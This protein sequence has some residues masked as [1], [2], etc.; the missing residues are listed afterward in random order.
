MTL[1]EAAAP[2]AWRTQAGP[3]SLPPHLQQSCH[4][5]EPKH[6][7]HFD[8]STNII[9][10]ASQISRLPVNMKSLP[11]VYSSHVACNGKAATQYRLPRRLQAD[12][13]QSDTYSYPAHQYC[14][15]RDTSF[16]ELRSYARGA[17]RACC[18]SMS[19]YPRCT[20]RAKTLN[21]IGGDKGH[22][23]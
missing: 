16:L 17:H 22:V 21:E 6:S 3:V 8:V 10:P 14:Q 11:D 20:H 4:R 9:P 7:C 12:V 1:L 2:C 13:L 19:P 5:L 23:Q 18:C 15:P